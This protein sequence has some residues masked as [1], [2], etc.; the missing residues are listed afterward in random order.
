MH[1]IH[2]NIYSKS[3]SYYFKQ[4]RLTDWDKIKDITKDKI[5]RGDNISLNEYE[6]YISH[7]KIKMIKFD[8]FLKKYDFIIT[9][10]TLGFG[11]NSIDEEK[12]DYCLI[13][14]FLG[15]PSINL[16]LFTSLD[17]YPFGLQV[18]GKRYDDL[19][20]L[21]FCDLLIKLGLCPDKS[22]IPEKIK[23]F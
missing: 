12:D 13:W 11:L 21:H 17:G 15:L 14:T 2:D 22:I 16:P 19:N 1:V 7:Q 20:L 9:P 3:L 8:S 23:F 10:S 18:V 4:E 6:N 5:K